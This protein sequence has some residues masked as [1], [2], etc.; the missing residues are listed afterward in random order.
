[1]IRPRLVVEVFEELVADPTDSRTDQGGGTEEQCGDA[2]E[3]T[4]QAVHFPTLHD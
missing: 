4:V 3:V 2:G 1:M